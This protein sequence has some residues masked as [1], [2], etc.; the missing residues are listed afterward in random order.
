MLLDGVRRYRYFTDTKIGKRAFVD[1]GSFVEL[2][3]EFIDDPV[4]LTLFYCRLNKLGFIPV[5]KVLRY[6]I[7]YVFNTGLYDGFIVAGTVLTKQV[8]EHVRWHDGIALY[9]LCEI[10]TDNL[11][12][13][14]SDCFGIDGVHGKP[15]SVKNHLQK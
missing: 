4:L 15:L 13:K 14:N 7:A 5:D 6:D 9:Y 10:L 11:S 2:R 12:R 8:F 3:R 1:T